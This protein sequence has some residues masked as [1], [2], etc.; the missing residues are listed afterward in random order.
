MEQ[1]VLENARLMW[2]RSVEKNRR[3]VEERAEQLKEVSNISALIAGFALIAF[4]EFSFNIDEVPRALVY[5]FGITSAVTVGL[6][7][8]SMVTCS[9]MHASI[10]KTGKR[11]VSEVDEANFIFRCR[12]FAKN[13][14]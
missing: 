1:R 14:A 10:L 5:G 2:D 8:N 11:Y 12:D 13:Y 6:M 7:V 3:A 9:F 4:L